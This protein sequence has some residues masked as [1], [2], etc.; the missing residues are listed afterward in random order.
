[1]GDSPE[2]WTKHA[3]VVT[4]S[5]VIETSGKPPVILRGLASEETILEAIHGRGAD[6]GK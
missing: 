3:I 2:L 5:L 6:A 1:L 4:P